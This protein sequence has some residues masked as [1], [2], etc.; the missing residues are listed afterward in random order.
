VQRSTEEAY[1]VIDE[2]V[3]RTFE[4]KQKQKLLEHFAAGTTARTAAAIVNVNKNTAQLFFYRLRELV[5]E[6]QDSGRIFEGEI[7]GS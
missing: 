7:L 6:K 3:E 2:F 4:K 5:A 1:W